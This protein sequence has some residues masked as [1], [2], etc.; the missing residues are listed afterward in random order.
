MTRL[1][2][3]TLLIVLVFSVATSGVFAAGPYGTQTQ[4]QVMEQIQSGECVGECDCPNCDGDCPQNCCQNQNR[5]GASDPDL[6]LIEWIVQLLAGQWQGS[7][8]PFH[9]GW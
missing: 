2:V 9:G 7:P 1:A 4:Q 8:G 6:G 5:T 3:L